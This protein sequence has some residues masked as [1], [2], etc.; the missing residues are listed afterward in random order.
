MSDSTTSLLNS[1]RAA[2]NLS[3]ADLADL[4]SLATSSP[5][6]G[7]SADEV[8]ARNLWRDE[9]QRFSVTLNDGALALDLQRPL[10]ENRSLEAVRRE[11]EARELAAAKADSVKTATLSAVDQVRMARSG[12]SGEAS[13]SGTRASTSASSGFA[14]TSSIVAS[15]PVHTCF[16]CQ[17][18]VPHSITL[19]CHHRYCA[20]CL[21]EL[22]VL[23]TKDESLHPASCCTAKI[24]LYLVSNT[25]LTVQQTLAYSAASKETCAACKAPEHPSTQACAAD[26]DDDAAAKLATQLRGTRCSKCHRV[27]MRNGGYP[28]IMCRCGAS[29]TIEAEGARA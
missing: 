17:E 25:V 28:S 29:L 19:S 26:G 3:L 12:A 4:N 24:P 10:R 23:A 27:V 21:R 6:L 1:L 8:L 13:T 15:K 5:R 7:A 22:F 20:P 11:R 2:T 16:I 9:L 14:S 18:R